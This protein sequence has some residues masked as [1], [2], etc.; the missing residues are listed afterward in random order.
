MCNTELFMQTGQQSMHIKYCTHSS[1]HRMM[2]LIRLFSTI[3]ILL[4][5]SMSTLTDYVHLL[6]VTVYTFYSGHFYQDKASCRKARL[7]G[8]CLNKHA[9]EFSLLNGL[10]F[11]QIFL[12]S[13]K[14]LRP[15]Y[16]QIYYQTRPLN[17]FIKD[18]KG[19]KDPRPLNSFRTQTRPI[20][21]FRSKIK[22]LNLSTRLLKFIQTPDQNPTI[23]S[24]PFN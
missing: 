22:P 24:D 18:H 3:L 20:H 13:Y 15:I 16:F 17:L 14:L 23:I 8:S 5:Y 10:H 11:H 21:L 6:I 4:C 12:T 1:V 9:I 19:N 7:L 2:L